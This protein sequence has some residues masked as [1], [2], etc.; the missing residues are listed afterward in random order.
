M[1]QLHQN[2]LLIPNKRGRKSVR[3]LLLLALFCGGSGAIMAII[4]DFLGVYSVQRVQLRSVLV[5]LRIVSAEKTVEL[6]QYTE[7][8]VTLFVGILLALVIL[9]SEAL[10]RKIFLVSSSILLIIGASLSL[11]L[12][13][14]W[15]FPGLIISGAILSSLLSIVCGLKIGNTVIEQESTK[16]TFLKGEAVSQSGGSD[17]VSDPKPAP[18]ESIPIPRIGPAQKEGVLKLNRGG[19]KDG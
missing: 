9:D 16:D 1:D 14:L 8:G 5:D 13:H 3:D 10:W 11:A 4:F 17:S 2:P 15:M 18:A 12:W 7:Y 6:A 19:R